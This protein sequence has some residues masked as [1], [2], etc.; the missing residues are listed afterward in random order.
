MFFYQ[1]AE[2]DELYRISSSYLNLT[3]FGPTKAIING[4]IGEWEYCDSDLKEN[5]VS[6]GYWDDSGKKMTLGDY[7]QLVNFLVIQEKKRI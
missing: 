1:D 2:V 6:N 3:V 7:S 5:E 4:T